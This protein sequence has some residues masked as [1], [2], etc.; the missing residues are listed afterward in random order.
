MNRNQ[1]I[2][3]KKRIAKDEYYP[4]YEERERQKDEGWRLLASEEL[5]FFEKAHVVLHTIIWA[6]YWRARIAI[7]N[8]KDREER[9]K[10]IRGEQYYP[11]YILDIEHYTN[12]WLVAN[13]K[14]L[15]HPEIIKAISERFYLK[16]ETSEYLPEGMT[17]YQFKQ[18]LSKCGNTNFRKLVYQ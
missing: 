15:L 17:M 18:Y 5:S 2:S 7:E 1:E 14:R 3:V 6:H 8:C 9:L 12:H 10:T 16:P 13:G 11:C 4:S